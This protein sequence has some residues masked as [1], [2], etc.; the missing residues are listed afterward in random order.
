MNYFG[1]LAGTWCLLLSVVAE[2][3]RPE[4]V[5]VDADFPGGNIEI[6]SIAGNEVFLHQDL[7]DTEINW[8]YWYFRVTGAAGKTLIFHF[9]HPW[10]SIPAMN[11]IGVRGPAVSRD[12]G[13]TWN[14]LGAEAVENTRFRYTFPADAGEVRFSFG[15]PY[16]ERN[17]L[18][19]LD[20]AGPTQHLET[21]ALAHTREGREVER[22]HLGAIHGK[23][24]FRILLT[25]RHHACEM[26]ASYVLEGVLQ[27]VLAHEGRWLREHVEWLV[28]PFVD[29]DGVEN[30]DQGKGRRAR[31]HNRD[32]QGESIYASTDALRAY[33]PVWL[34]NL[35]AMAIDLHCPSIRGTTNERIYFVQI[36]DGA[37]AAAVNA[38]SGILE[39]QT[40]SM[41]LPFRASHNM[42]FGTGWNTPANYTKGKSMAS[43]ASGFDQVK[44]AA[45][46]EFPY[47]NASGAEVTAES[48]R[49]FGKA[50]ALSIQQ[51]LKDNHIKY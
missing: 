12:G 3:Q 36:D 22:I 33:F 4:A 18:A 37:N 5:R 9:T 2:A 40:A 38:L 46:L 20:R 24:R 47:A 35:P 19:F 43:W 11:V 31:D 8:F 42:P 27:T 51:Y 17:L 7:H 1:F 44:L 50:L 29:K 41:S 15:M 23:P 14:W 45:T 30:G 25:A 28:I 39:Q 16:T 6:D 34:E 21:H 49:D 13:W 26:M 32:Y 10:E 48:A